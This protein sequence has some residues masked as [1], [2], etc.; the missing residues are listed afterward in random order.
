M[1]ALDTKYAEEMLKNIENP[2][3]KDIL[4]AYIKTKEKI[5]LREDNILKIPVFYNNNICIDKRYVFWKD[6]YKKDIRFINDLVK[7]NRELYSQEE[8]IERYNI[9]T[10]Y[11]HYQGII[12]SIKI[13]LNKLKIILSTKIEAPFIPYHLKPIL[14]QKTGAQSIYIIF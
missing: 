7:E 14:Q 1:T 4:T 13:Y 9:T 3:W 12:K 5:E 11:L 8:L 6:W 10:N 2:F